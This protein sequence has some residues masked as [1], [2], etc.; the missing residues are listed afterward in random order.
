M[1]QPV[2]GRDFSAR[3]AK[4]E[5]DLGGVFPGL[6]LWG[7]LQQLAESVS[8]DALL[9]ALNLYVKNSNEAPAQQRELSLRLTT[10]VVSRPRVLIEVCRTTRLAVRRPDLTHRLCRHALQRADCAERALILAYAA[11]AGL[12]LKE[13]GPVSPAATVAQG[14]Y[15]TTAQ[16]D[17]LERL[18][19]CG[20]LYFNPAPSGPL[21]PRLIPL[22]VG[23]SGSG[24]THL[25]RAFAR[26]Q[27]MPI[28]RL[29]VGDWIVSGARRTS[30]LEQL[31]VFL[32]THD[33]FVLHLDELDKFKMHDD[34]WS[35]AV[36]GELFA[37]LDRDVSAAVDGDKPWTSAHA[38]KLKHQVFIV[39]SGTWQELWAADT[40]G[41]LGFHPGGVS[42][43]ESAARR[44]AR[45][46]Q[47][48]LIPAELLNRFHDRWL[49]L[50]N[51]TTG[52]FE[53]IAAKLGFNLSA[54]DPVAAVRSRLNFRY[55]ENAYTEALLTE[56]LTARIAN[57]N[58]M[59][60]R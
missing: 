52:D 25:V 47:A 55:V 59:A 44:C 54:L 12:C 10:A 60:P 18:R 16:T 17:A 9:R 28:L 40:G 32:D 31:R 6:Q 27:S 39:G 43:P 23:P 14:M 57:L 58:A 38:E 41:T 3:R 49:V 48:S 50:E 5:R 11:E 35:H 26:E 46:R 20:D 37:V 1:V 21:T 42:Q 4:S 33:R 29:T 8:T 30:T 24:K 13:D 53:A 2:R 22:L 56:R 51:Y 34:A 36:F 7:M 45:I 15:L 19:A